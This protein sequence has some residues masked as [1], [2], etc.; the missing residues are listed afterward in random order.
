MQGDNMET[1]TDPADPRRC[2]S[3][4]GPSQCERFAE[5]GS[6]CCAKHG[7]VDH[8]NEKST[9]LYLL[10]KADSQKRLLELADHEEI[11]SLREEIAIVRMLIEQ[12]M[13]MI[14]ND[15]DLLVH[16]G[17]INSLVLTIERLVKSAH[18]IE[19][20]LGILLSKS[21]VIALGQ[22][23][24]KIIVEEL[25][26]I[27]NYE[28]IVDSIMTRISTSIAVAKDNPGETMKTVAAKRLDG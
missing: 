4:D 25:D 10:A 3:S 22:T 17:A 24:C 16:S 27:E 19:Q 5:P 18:T 2:K 12:R 26:G 8:T 28:E 23:I 21:A 13:N 14:K 20:N 11:R 9:R 15:T 6:D 7:G 1:V